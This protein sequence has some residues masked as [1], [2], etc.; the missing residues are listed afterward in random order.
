MKSTAEL[1][2]EL[3]ARA[4]AGESAPALLGWLRVSLGNRFSHVLFL[5][6]LM[7]GIGLPLRVGREVE[8]WIGLSPNGTLSDEDLVKLL[9]PWLSQHHHKA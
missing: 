9:Q 2:T 3:R 5:H 8:N 4:A 6:V 1:A 7:E